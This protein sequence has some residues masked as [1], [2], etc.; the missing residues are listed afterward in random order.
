MKYGWTKTE[1]AGCYTSLTLGASNLVPDSE[2]WEFKSQSGLSSKIVLESELHQGSDI[3]I[4]K[5]IYLYSYDFPT[6]SKAK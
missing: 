1:V 2:N 4:T 5:S 6:K 3:Q